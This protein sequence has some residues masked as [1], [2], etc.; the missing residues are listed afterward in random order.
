MDLLSPIKDHHSE[1]KLFIARVILSSFIAVLLLGIVVSRLVQLQ[2]FDHE[3][4]AERSQGNR[5][6]IEPVPPIRGLILDRKGRV[7]AENFPTYQLELV[8]EQVED[9]DRTLA[10]LADLGLIDSARIPDLRNASRRGPHFKPVTLNPHLSDDEIAKFA[11]E[12]PRFPASISSRV[13]FAPTR[14]ARLSRMRL[15]TS[16]RCRPRTCSESTSPATPARPT[17]ARPASSPVTSSSCTAIPVID[18]W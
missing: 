14:T 9:L 18:T 17:A 10:A 11:V 16:G 7:L 8:P 1:R 15:A 2:V 5:V 13:S 3:Y 12:R 4:F 6:R